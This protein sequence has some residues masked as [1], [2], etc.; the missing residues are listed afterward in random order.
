MSNTRAG[1]FKTETPRCQ[2]DRKAKSNAYALFGQI[3]T[4]SCIDSDYDA[5][6]ISWVGM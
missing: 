2:P 4:Y 3:C 1:F 6:D 5:R